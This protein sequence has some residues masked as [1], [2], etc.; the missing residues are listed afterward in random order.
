MQETMMTLQEFLDATSTVPEPVLRSAMTVAL[1]IEPARTPG[2]YQ[3]F[4]RRVVDELGLDVEPASITSGA[5]Q[6]AA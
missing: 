4:Y 6:A 5:R 1:A 2:A 3:R